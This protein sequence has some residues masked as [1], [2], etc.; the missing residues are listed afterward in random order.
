M[1]RREGFAERADAL[2]NGAN[3]TSQSGGIR[4]TIHQSCG[5]LGNAALCNNYR[6]GRS[7]GLD[8]CSA[9]CCHSS[10]C[11]CN[12]RICVRLVREDRTIHCNEIL[13]ADQIIELLHD[14]VD[15]VKQAV[16]TIS[17][18]D[19]GLSDRLAVVG[20]LGEDHVNRTRIVRLHVRRQCLARL[21]HESIA[22][23]H[24][25]IPRLFALAR[26]FLVLHH[27]LRDAAEV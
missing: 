1:H 27:S 25:P 8:H 2:T 17:Q 24:K 26:Q 13:R 19:E 11:S 20:I 4:I 15:L 6:Q 10:T 22:A 7:L 9:V 5:E 12:L 14:R 16:P 18:C 23:L 3:R 21:F